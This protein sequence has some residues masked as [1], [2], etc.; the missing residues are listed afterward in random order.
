[1]ASLA[2]GSVSH[3]SIKGYLSAIRHLQITR[4][5]YDPRFSDMAV[6]QY[7]LQ[8]IKRAQAIT[9]SHPTRTRLPIT[10]NVMRV[11]RC[12][13][14]GQGVTLGHSLHVLLWLLEI[15]GGHRSLGHVVR[16]ERAP[17]CRR[18]LSR[19]TSITVQSHSAEASKTDPFREGITVCLRRTN[20]AI[21]GLFQCPG[22]AVPFRG[23]PASYKT[24]IGAGGTGR[25]AGGWPG[26]S[27]LRRSQLQNWSG[28]DSRRCR[29]Q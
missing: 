7:V 23:W 20:W 13:W 17:V 25:V 21:L 9:G 19:C 15:R 10:A 28:D 14:E 22:T 4:L 26:P 2:S 1:M 18:R 12:S 24:R 8:G 27:Q 5:G 29:C 3:K 11:L 16:P 6:L